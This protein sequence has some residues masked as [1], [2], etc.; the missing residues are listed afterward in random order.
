MYTHIDHS[1]VDGWVT[2]GQPLDLELTEVKQASASSAT[3]PKLQT[4]PVAHLDA[5]SWPCGV[6]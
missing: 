1:G 6:H 4:F 3:R 2:L 5:K